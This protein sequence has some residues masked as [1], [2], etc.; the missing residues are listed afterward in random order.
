MK[1]AIAG[2][3]AM[4]SRF[5]YQ[6]KKAGQDVTLI[7]PW[8]DHVEAIREHGLQVDYDGQL[9][10]VEIPILYPQEV[11]ESYDLVVCFTKALGLDAM[12][13]NIKPALGEHTRVLC[14]LNG[15]GH[16]KTVEK[17]VPAE[18]FL[19]GNTIWT[20]GLDGPGKAHLYGSGS[21]ALQNVVPGHEE[22]AKEVAELLDQAGLNATFDANVRYSIYRKAA[23]N[24]CVNGVCALL[25]CNLGSFG[26]TDSAPVIIRE[27]VSEF[28]AVAAQEGIILD[29]PE[30]VSY[31][32]SI[33]SPDSIGEH[34][35]SLHQ[36]LVQ[37]GRL[38]E[39]DFINGAI[40]RQAVEYGFRAPYCELI[41][42]L[43]HSKEQILGAK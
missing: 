11:T 3:G 24:G 30:V 17:Y 22:Q 7:D 23:L 6:L 32:E 28:A 4:G 2:A 43:V 1:I 41:T 10:S 21:L 18:N 12:L 26:S 25:D 29:Q 9:D 34:F 39:I 40:A 20:A 5:G 19:I 31:V 15:L 13:A 42:L 14:L 36:D 27:V 38:T 8:T 16:E 37:K 35:P 33:F